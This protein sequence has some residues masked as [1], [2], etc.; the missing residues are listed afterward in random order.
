[1][2]NKDGTGLRD[3]VKLYTGQYG[4][5]ARY[6]DCE[7]HF[8]GWPAGDWV[9]YE[10][11]PKTG[12]IWRVN[13]NNTAL[14]HM[15]VRYNDAGVRPG[16][17]ACD[18]NGSE[19][20]WLRRWQL[21][22]DAKY[23]GG[24]FKVYPDAQQLPHRFP[25]PEGYAP[26]TEPLWPDLPACNLCISASGEYLSAY[27]AG[28]HDASSMNLWNHVTNIG[29]RYQ[30]VSGGSVGL[31][32]DI[33]TWCGRD[34]GNL[35]QYMRWAANSDK[36]LL[37]QTGYD[38]SGA[39]SSAGN[40]VLCN[41]KDRAGMCLTGV[42]AGASLGYD[43][44]DLWI[45]DPTNNPGGNK[46]EDPNGNWVTVTPRDIYLTWTVTGI[47]LTHVSI[48]AYPADAEVRYT[49]DGADPTQSSNLYA[50]QLDLTPGAGRVMQVKA[51]AFRTGMGP[52][53][54]ESRLI[55]P[56][57]KALPAG[58]VKE[59]L[60][61]ETTLGSMVVPA[62]DTAAVLAKYAGENKPC[63]FDGDQVTVNAHTYTWHL[64][65]D[66]DGVWSPATGSNSLTFW[67]TTIVT[68]ISRMAKLGTRFHGNP[69]MY[70]NGHVAWTFDGWDSNHEWIFAAGD[71]AAVG[72]VKGANGVLMLQHA[73]GVFGVRFLSRSNDSDLTDLQYFPYSGNSAGRP[74]MAPLGR[75]GADVS[76]VT[77]QLLI[78]PGAAHAAWISDVNG[79]T[80]RVVRGLNGA[81]CRLPLKD[82]GD[83]MHLVT[84]VSDAGEQT[85]RVLVR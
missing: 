6:A 42:Y 25:P 83:G 30:S 41:W 2:V 51:R 60:C 38:C 50:A 15:V 77:G 68:P 12:E 69:R 61:L 4:W 8:V 57:S 65:T 20:F 59:L 79:R 23:C 49:T 78:L 33:R 54:T 22:A 35:G 84:L 63:P 36:W 1:V 75:A 45:S 14:H 26:L 70:L 34:V 7:G 24:M 67:Y 53:E 21:S 17:C 28:C 58:Y 27:F 76:I 16:N 11:P 32:T 40:Q 55:V 82:L 29:P 18:I 3:L 47:G 37:V 72:L 74:V 81:L 52:A 5:S 13:V 19:G 66:D 71:G 31:Y 56:S 10:K 39:G 73:D 43:A 46:Y 80:E 9:Y 44:G 85:W 48:A 62:A 64:R